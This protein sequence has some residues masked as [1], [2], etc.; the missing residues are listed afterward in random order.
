MEAVD[1]KL[2]RFQS[3]AVHRLDID[4][5]SASSLEADGRRLGIGVDSVG[6]GFHDG[7]VFVDAFAELI[8]EFLAAQLFTGDL[9]QS[10]SR[11]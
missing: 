4:H 5:V 11:R 1:S 8:P 7:R 9:I 2:F 3:P 10:R 6:E